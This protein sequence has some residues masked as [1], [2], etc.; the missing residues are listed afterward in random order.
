MAPK[1]RHSKMKRLLQEHQAGDHNDRERMQEMYDCQNL[2]TS[3]TKVEGS[4]SRTSQCNNVNVFQHQKKRLRSD[5]GNVTAIEKECVFSNPN[6]N[7][8]ATCQA[9]YTVGQAVYQRSR[10]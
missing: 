3:V 6:S 1:M 2:Y 10:Q 7:V 9:T 4:E 5:E 8:F